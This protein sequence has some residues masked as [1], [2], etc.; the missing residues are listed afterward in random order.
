M[1]SDNKC[2]EEYKG[3]KVRLIIEDSPFP[4]PRDGTIVNISDTHIFLKVDGKKFLVPFLLSTIRRID[5][6]EDK[7]LEEYGN[8]EQE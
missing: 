5:I 1:I 7:E 4:K 6:K 8:N 3:K 2:W